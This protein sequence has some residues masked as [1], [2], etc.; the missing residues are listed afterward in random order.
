VQQDFKGTVSNDYEHYVRA[1]G[2]Y[3]TPPDSSRLLTKTS[4]PW[5]R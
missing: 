1:S 4:M 3:E 5:A 2:Y